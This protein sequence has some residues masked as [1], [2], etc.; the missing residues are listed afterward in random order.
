MKLQEAVDRLNKYHPA[1]LI[2]GISKPVDGEW[3]LNS[4]LVTDKKSYLEA[5]K[6]FELYRVFLLKEG[7]VEEVNKKYNQ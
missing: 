6:H 7:V 1:I 4:V 5:T 3:L 2:L